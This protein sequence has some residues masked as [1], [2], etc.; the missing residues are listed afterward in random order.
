MAIEMD[1]KICSEMFS[2]PNILWRRKTYLIRRVVR[3]GLRELDGLRAH[4]AIN[5]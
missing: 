2:H 4:K 5:F 3:R 1:L